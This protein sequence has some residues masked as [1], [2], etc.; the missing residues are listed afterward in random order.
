MT[1]YTFFRDLYSLDTLDT[2]LTTSSKTPA[3]DASNASAKTTSKD[4]VTSKDLPPGASASKWGTPEFYLYTLVFVVAVP[5]MY[6]AVWNVSQTS[7]PHYAEYEKLL[8]D[9]WLFG[10]K[11]DNSDG[12]YSGFRENLPALSLLLLV[13]PLLRRLYNSVFSPKKS[14]SSQKPSLEINSGAEGFSSRIN[15]DFVSGIVFISALHG[16]SALKILTL[17]Y[18][19]YCIALRLPRGYVPAATW[20]FNIAVLFANELARGYQFSSIAEAVAPFYAGA[21]DAGKFLDGWGGLIPRWEVHFNITIL[22]LVAFNMDY[23]WSLARDRAGSPLE[24]SSDVLGLSRER[25]LIHQRRN[26]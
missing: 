8:S 16:F 12:Q 2:R 13:H 25:L 21:A 4:V 26:S 11:V 5:S 9:G 3:K 10:R 7:S 6:F 14:S 1:V 19:N 18:I 15:F 23:Y 22:R 17:L 20:I 24:V